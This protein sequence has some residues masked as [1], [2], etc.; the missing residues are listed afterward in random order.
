MIIQL[1]LDSDLHLMEKSVWVSIS[2][3]PNWKQLKKPGSTLKSVNKL[4]MLALKTEF[5]KRFDN[6]IIK[7]SH[8]KTI[9]QQNGNKRARYT[10]T[11]RYTDFS[12]SKLS[13]IFII[14]IS[15]KNGWLI[16][17]EFSIK[18][19]WTKKHQYILKIAVIYW[20]Q[21]FHNKPKPH[22]E[23]TQ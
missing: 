11:V 2:K 19:V 10:Y 12:P 17:Y 5:T 22:D 6:K 14:F 8:Q 4:K 15:M 20:R 18:S 9:F 23:I 3:C 16:F 13:H 21:R 7:N 1:Y